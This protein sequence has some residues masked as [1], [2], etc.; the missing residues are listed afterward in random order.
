MARHIGGFGRLEAPRDGRDFN[1]L[2]RAARLQIIAA[3]G[4]PKPRARAYREGPILDQGM[5]PWCV[6]FSQRGFVNAAPLMKGIESLGTEGEFYKECQRNDE[7]P[8]ESYEGSSVRAGQKVALARKIIASYVWGQTVEEAMKWMNDG[9]GTVIVG[10][11]WYQSMDDVGPDG[12]IKLPGTLATPI[13]GH[14]YRWNWYDKKKGGILVYNSWGASWG[15][16]KKGGLFTGY[17]YLRVEDAER[18][19]RESG[20]AAAPTQV[21]IKPVIL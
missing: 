9:Y 4:K 6:E 13:G 15:I 16:P 1:F 19:L 12:F 18:L 8:G 10:T 21:S 5:K 2:M 3:V 17:A 20:E 7:W 11:D 14:A